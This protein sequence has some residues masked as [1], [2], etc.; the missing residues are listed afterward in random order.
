MSPS[1]RA[2]DLA[3]T[4]QDVRRMDGDL[5]ELFERSPADP[6]HTAPAAEIAFVLGLVALGHRAVLADLRPLR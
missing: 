2:Y 3:M 5:G 6:A 4:T 1:S